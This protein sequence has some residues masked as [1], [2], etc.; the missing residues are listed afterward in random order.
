MDQ[1]RCLVFQYITCYSLSVT[2][3]AI[4]LIC[5]SFNTSHVTL[6]H[7]ILRWV[8]LLGGV[9]IH[10]MLLFIMICQRPWHSWPGFNTSHVTLYRCWAC[11]PYRS[12]LVSIHHMLL[13]ICCQKHLYFSSCRFQYITC[14]SLSM[15]LGSVRLRNRRFQ[16]I[17]CY[18][19][20]KKRE[21][22]CYK[23]NLFQYITCYSL[24][25][26]RRF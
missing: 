5:G 16:Y 18:S 11:I 3:K 9:S 15:A 14:Y 6:Y 19:L 12:I 7:H 22:F 4:S 1:I 25:L 21:L 17:T 26:Q 10:H 2:Q 24:S 23:S 8:V 20:S 13:F